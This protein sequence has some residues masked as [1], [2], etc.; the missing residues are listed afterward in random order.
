M[1][2]LQLEDMLKR[3]ADD[4]Y[5]ENMQSEALLSAIL[6]MLDIVTITSDELGYIRGILRTMDQRLL[7]IEKLAQ[8]QDKNMSCMTNSRSLK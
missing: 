6:V 1:T 7:R 2:L 8:K 4:G 3:L 5:S